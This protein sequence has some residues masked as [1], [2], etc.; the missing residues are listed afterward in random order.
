MAQQT[1]VIST[2]VHREKERPLVSVAAANAGLSVAAYVRLVVLRDARERIAKTV[3][4][5][6][7]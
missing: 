3:E 1:V 2:K 7:G 6:A 5:A 4:A